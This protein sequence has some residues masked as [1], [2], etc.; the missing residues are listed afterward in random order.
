ML[1]TMS[2]PPVLGSLTGTC[3][4][5]A[6]ECIS[7]TQRV[8]FYVGMGLVAIGIGGHR[9]LLEPYNDDVAVHNC[10]ATGLVLFV[11]LTAGF[12]TFPYIKQ[13]YILFGVA[14]F[15]VIFATILF[16]CGWREYNYKAEPQAQGRPL[17]DVCRVFVAAARKSFQPLPVLESRQ[18]YKRDD[19]ESHISL[20]TCHFLGYKS[21]FTDHLI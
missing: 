14:A 17:I 7:E 16:L 15:Y 3:E 13:W 18:F 5:Y 21:T 20:Q 6:A 9:A 11:G 4:V 10:S 8:V 12:I 1:V 19:D 2:T